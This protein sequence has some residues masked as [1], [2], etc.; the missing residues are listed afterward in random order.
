MLYKR[1]I[2][3]N[4]LVLFIFFGCSGRIFN[5]ICLNSSVSSLQKETDISQ[6]KFDKLLEDIKLDKL[7]SGLSKQN[8]MRFYGEP[9]LVKRI[10]SSPGEEWLYRAPLE[11]FETPKVYLIFDSQEELLKWRIE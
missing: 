8:I 9:V 2:L 11:Y 10:G 4:L 1:Y 5:L 3:I 6:T 7:K